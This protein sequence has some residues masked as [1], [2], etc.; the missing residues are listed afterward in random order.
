MSVLIVENYIFIH[1]SML[2]TPI[3]VLFLKNAA[4]K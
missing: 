3:N 1:K 2:K 4:H